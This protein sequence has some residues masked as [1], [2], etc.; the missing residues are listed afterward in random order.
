MDDQKSS[1]KKKHRQEQEQ[2][3]IISTKSC[4]SAIRNTEIYIDTYIHTFM[5]KLAALLEYE[6]RGLCYI[7]RLRKEEENNG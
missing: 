6:V 5:Q 3:S 1:K 7:R 2:Y 4:A